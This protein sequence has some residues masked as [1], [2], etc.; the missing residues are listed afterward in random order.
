MALPW[1]L[2]AAHSS[3]TQTLLAGEWQGVLAQEGSE[4]SVSIMFKP[5]AN[6]FSGTMTMSSVGMFRPPLSKVTVNGPKVHFEQENLQSRD[7]FG[8]AACAASV[9]P[10][11]ALLNSSP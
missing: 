6:E 7:D 11:D 1:I 5:A 9:V 8:V 2:V 3:A 4:A 10:Q